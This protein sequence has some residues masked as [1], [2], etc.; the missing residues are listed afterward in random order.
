MKTQAVSRNYAIRKSQTGLRRV[1][2]FFVNSDA[3]V[4]LDALRFEALSSAG[5]CAA[6]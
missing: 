6:R 2:E 3:N 5:L 1:V 4:A